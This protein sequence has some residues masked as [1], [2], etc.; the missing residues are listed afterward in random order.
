MLQSSR[1]A[2]AQGNGDI[3]FV[4]EDIDFTNHLPSGLQAI[5]SPGHGGIALG[6]RSIYALRPVE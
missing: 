1:A 2:L 4:F 3:L 5:S 6:R